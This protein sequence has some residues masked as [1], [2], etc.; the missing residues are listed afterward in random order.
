[1]F[2][3]KYMEYLKL[4]TTNYTLSDIESLFPIIN[5]KKIIAFKK[6]VYIEIPSTSAK[7]LNF[8][9]K[10]FLSISDSESL[11]LLRVFENKTGLDIIN[12][13]YSCFKVKI[14]EDALDEFK[15]LKKIND[16]KVMLQ[17][18]LYKVNGRVGMSA[19]LVRHVVN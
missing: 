19:K 7:V 6:K 17:L 9:D 5:E 11:E 16:M 10:Y 18:F 12:K 4:N 8:E 1:M 15:E 14:G 13:K 3:Y 2:I